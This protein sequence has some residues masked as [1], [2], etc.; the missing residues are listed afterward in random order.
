M[1]RLLAAS[2]RLASDALY[3]VCLLLDEAAALVAGEEV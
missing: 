3:E 2:V 1:R